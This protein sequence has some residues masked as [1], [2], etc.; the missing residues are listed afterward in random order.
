VAALTACAPLLQGFGGHPRAAGLQ[1]KPGVLE[2]FRRQFAAACAAQRSHGD[3][4]PEL[5]VDGWL[6]PAEIGPGLWQALQR[7]EPF[8]EGHSR[9]RWGMRGLQL[10]T[11]PSPVGGSG[12]HLRLAFRTGATTLRGVWF[13]MG[14]LAE[15]VAQIGATPVDAVFELHE[16]TYGGQSS[17]E[18]QV[19]DLR[20]AV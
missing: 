4:R 13:K 1:L 11:P 2:E 16:N 17:L 15:E 6:T 9:P 14:K 3:A 20:P 12:E 18:M 19:V 8:G 5:L 7:L 10:A